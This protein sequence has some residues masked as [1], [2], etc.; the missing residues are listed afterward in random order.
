MVVP[1]QWRTRHPDG[2]GFS[3]CSV[4]VADTVAIVDR[5][6]AYRYT[7]GAWDGVA[8]AILAVD[9]GVAVSGTGTGKGAAVV[10]DDALSTGL[11]GRRDALASRRPSVAPSAWSR[12]G[13]LRGLRPRRWRAGGLPR[14]LDSR[15]HRAPRG[16]PV[17]PLCGARGGAGWRFQHNGVPGTPRGRGFPRVLIGFGFRSTPGLADIVGAGYPACPSVLLKLVGRIRRVRDGRAWW[18]FRP[19]SRARG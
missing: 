2:A 19:R 13:C 15:P 8:T 18:D 10:P 5:L 16:S 7:A 11:L 6:E 4:A 17:A 9:G 3:A 1:A 14:C 12:V